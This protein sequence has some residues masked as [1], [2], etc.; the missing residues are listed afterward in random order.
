VA[1]ALRGACLRSSD[2]AARYGGEELAL[3][4]PHTSRVGAEHVAHRV[5][6][7]VASLGI[8]HEASLTARTLTVSVGVA[9]YDEH[10][11]SWGERAAGRFVDT[12]APLTPSDL[13]RC[14]DKAL[15]DAKR[16]GR[17]QAWRRDIDDV[18][19]MG[20]PVPPDPATSPADKH[21]AP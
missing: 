17:A 9:C 3:L 1:Q 15:Y 14:A 12:H 20:R 11:R 4:L 10:S 21:A 16:G 19:A 13:V 6:D 2:L 7:A 5:L 8:P 18:E